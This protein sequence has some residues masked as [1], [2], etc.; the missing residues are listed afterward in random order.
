MIKE[1]EF[2]ENQHSLILTVTFH[3]STVVQHFPTITFH[4]STEV[5]RFLTVTFHSSMVVQHFPTVTFHSQ[6]VVRRFSTITFHSMRVVQCFFITDSR[7]HRCSVPEYVLFELFN[8]EKY[9]ST[10]YFPITAI[11]FFYKSCGTLNLFLE[12]HY[13]M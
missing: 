10:L 13:Q 7:I 8:Q 3:A 6:R 12:N 1:I 5:Q 2:I 11:Y 4:A 9:I